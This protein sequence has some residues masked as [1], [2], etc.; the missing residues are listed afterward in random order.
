MDCTLYIPIIKYVRKTVHYVQELERLVTLVWK[1][2][3]FIVHS[4]AWTLDFLLN[5]KWMYSAACV[6]VS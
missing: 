4:K 6:L 1:V 2:K 3:H 5:S